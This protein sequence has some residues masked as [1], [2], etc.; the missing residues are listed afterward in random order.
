MIRESLFRAPW[1][2]R[3]A[4]AQTCFASMIRTKQKA[5]ARD[6]RLEL[7]DGDFVDLTWFG[8]GI[9]PV[10]IILHGLGGSGESAYARGIVGPLTDRGFRVVIMHFRG[11]SGVPNRKL[12]AYHSGETEDFRYLVSVLR[13]RL[14][15]TP[16]GAVGYSLG[17]NVLLKYL[18]EEG[19]RASLDAAVSVCAPLVLSKC[20]ERLGRGL[21]RV[22][23]WYLLISLKRGLR[24]KMRS[25]GAGLHLGLEPRDVKR[26][27]TIPAFDEYVTAPLHG[28]HSAD[29]YYDKS[30]S[31]QFLGAIRCP[32]LVL[33]ARDDPFMQPDVL[34]EARE[35]SDSVELEISPG[36]GHVGFVTG[37]VPWKPIYW[38]DDKIPDYLTVRLRPD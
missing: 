21:S 7:P 10:I 3:N 26:I 13:E 9:G 14:G 34:P 12:R 33:Q 20:A 28:F 5:M 25:M 4:H 18:G 23:Q 19:E 35:L 38:L 16:L 29:D 1:W 2:L 32:V 31:R 11:C 24:E 27:R 30:S 15:S 17:G 36:G 37:P 6:E 22:Y 8:T